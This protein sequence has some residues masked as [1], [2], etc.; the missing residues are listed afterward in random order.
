MPLDP[1]ALDI[2]ALPPGDTLRLTLTAFTPPGE[3]GAI[4]WLLDPYSGGA[5]AGVVGGNTAIWRNQA[6]PHGCHGN[7]DD[8]FQLPTP[9]GAAPTPTASAT[10]WVPPYAGA[11]QPP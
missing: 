10:P 7:V 8:T 11:T 5:G 1:A 3:V 6:D 9:A 4:G 2:V